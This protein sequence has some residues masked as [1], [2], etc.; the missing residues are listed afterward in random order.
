MGIVTFGLPVDLA[1]ELVSAGGLSAAVETGTYLGDSAIALR[2]L[3]PTVVSIELLDELYEKAKRNVGN[4][5]GIKLLKGYSPRVLSEIVDQ[6][7]GPTLFWLDAHGGTEGVPDLDA[8]FS[9]CP[10]MDELSAIAK[11]PL[12][13]RSCI[14]IDDARAFFGP[15]LQHTPSQWP[16]FS[17]VSDYLRTMGDRYVTVLDD[18]IIAV[19]SDLQS[20]VNAWWRTKLSQRHGYEALQ[21]RVQQLS[22]PSPLEASVRLARSL[23]PA[24]LR[25]SVSLLLTKHGVKAPAARQNYLGSDQ[26][27]GD[28]Q[29]KASPRG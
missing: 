1:R 25:N 18:V 24:R 20:T 6:L 17:E 14:I 13:D 10:L 2:D 28:E 22:D 7:S 11:F 23:L 19:P 8:E 5:D 3:V 26:I 4:R 21:E 27:I 15:M 16:T 9:E 29:A 12:A